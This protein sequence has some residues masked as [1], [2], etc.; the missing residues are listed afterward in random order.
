MILSTVLY[1]RVVQLFGWT[2]RV[3][4]LYQ[5]SE[6]IVL[7]EGEGKTLP[8]FLLLINLY[9]EGYPSFTLRMFFFFSQ[10]ISWTVVTSLIVCK[11]CSGCNSRTQHACNIQARP[12]VLGLRYLEPFYYR[13]MVFFLSQFGYELSCF[14]SILGIQFI[15]K[16]NFYFSVEAAL[17]TG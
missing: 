4:C 13:Y 5:Q 11:M 16:L 12:G 10:F 15:D 8:L 9:S 6:I 3:I 1:L 2:N 7:R 14:S 17:L